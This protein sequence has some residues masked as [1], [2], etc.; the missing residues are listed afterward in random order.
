MSFATKFLKISNY[1][2]I[3]HFCSEICLL[4]VSIRVKY[5]FWKI[6]QKHDA[7]TQ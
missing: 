3:I 6:K 1:K 4:S 2:E 7:I 5:V